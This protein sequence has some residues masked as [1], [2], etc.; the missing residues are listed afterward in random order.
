M[1]AEFAELIRFDP[2]GLSDEAESDPGVRTES[3]LVIPKAF[4]RAG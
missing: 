1:E 2:G 4:G 3:G